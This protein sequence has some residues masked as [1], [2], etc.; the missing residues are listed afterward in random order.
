MSR[1]FKAFNKHLT[2][3][4]LPLHHRS[5]SPAFITSSSFPLFP[6]LSAVAYPSF[7]F[8]Q[9][10]PLSS[11][12]PAALMEVVKAIAKHESAAHDSVAIRADQQSYS[13]KQLMSSAQKISNLLCGSDAQIGNLGG[14]RIGILAKPSAEFVAGLLG[15]WISGG[16]AVPLAISYPEVELLYVINNSVCFGIP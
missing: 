2:L 12:P 9:F 7:S 10:R 5:T 8:S 1:S 3:L 11:S 6:H 4:P 13:Y 14:A 15:I 16:V